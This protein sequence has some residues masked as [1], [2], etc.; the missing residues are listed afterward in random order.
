ME[1]EEID[2]AYIEKLERYAEQT[3]KTIDYSLERFDILIISLAT[4]GLVLSIGF[5][6]DI[7]G[8]FSKVNP[9]LLQLTWLL[10]A[11]CLVSNLLSQVTSYFANRLDLKITKYLIKK[12]KGKTTRKLNTLE[13]RHKLADF[14][15]HVF[16]AISLICFIGGITTLIWFVFKYI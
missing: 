3:Q 6:K 9:L 5:V 8:D 2:K 11:S 13:L 14:L 10:F 15:T 16:N 1:K 7:I 12:E 4:T